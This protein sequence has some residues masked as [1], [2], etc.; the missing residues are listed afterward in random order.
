VLQG[1]ADQRRDVTDTEL[2]HKTGAVGVDAFG[3]E[4]ELGGDLG[5]G[6]PLDDQLENLQFPAA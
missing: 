1:K 5:A 3:G 6:P 2:L 4:G